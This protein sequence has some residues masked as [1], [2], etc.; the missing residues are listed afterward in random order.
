M[1]RAFFGL[2]AAG[3]VLA[4]LSLPA[5]ATSTTTST[6]SAKKHTAMAG[7]TMKCPF[8]GMT[9]TTKK[10]AAMPVPVKIKG[11]TYYC[12]TSCH[13]APAAKKSS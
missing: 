4:A 5:I 9:M 7:K 1:K 10:S 11:V 13:K 12:C 2:A 8:C 3:Y 6:K